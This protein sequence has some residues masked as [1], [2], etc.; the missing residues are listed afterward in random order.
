MGIKQDTEESLEKFD[1]TKIN[2]QPTNK[3]MNQ[4]TQE[5]GD[6][7][8]TIPTTNGG[9]DHGHIGMIHNNTEY[10]LFSTCSTSLVIHKNLSPFP[11]TIST[12]EVDHLCQL[13]QHKQVIIEYNT[14]QGCLQATR[15]KNIH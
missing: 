2:G 15:A 9:G 13:A 12:N 7:L 5:L 3:D 1:T 6:M 8:P 11:T 4:L 10:T 14:Y